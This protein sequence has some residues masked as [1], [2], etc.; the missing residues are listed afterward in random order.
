MSICSQGA[1]TPHHRLGGG[2][3]LAAGAKAPNA[4]RAFADP[5]I[6]TWR[7][8]RFVRCGVLAVVLGT[9]SL[10]P[11]GACHGEEVAAAAPPPTPASAAWDYWLRELR[12]GSDALEWSDRRVAHDWRLQEH[13]GGERWRLLDP[14]DE[15]V[16]AAGRTDCETTF[17]RLQAAGTIPTVSGPTV[18]VLHGLGQGRQSMQ[19]LVKHLRGTLDATVLSIGYASPRAGLEVHADALNEVISQLPEATT[20]SFVGHSLGNLVVRRW[21]ASAPAPTLSRVQ[22]MVMLGPPNQGSELARLASR[23]W[24]L[25][26]LSDGPT[27]QLG[28]E[29]NLVSSQLAVP[30]C[31]FG[32]VAGGLGD[33]RGMSMLLAGDDDAIVRVDETRLDGASGFLLLPVHHA[34][35]MRSRAVQRAAVCF[36]RDGFFPESPPP[37]IRV[38][39]ADRS[40]PGSPR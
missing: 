2:T 39:S 13:S 40:E 17:E 5:L 9:C 1:L 24:F 32:I 35:M 29:W 31:D 18:L 11:G 22:R 8:A 27:R 21:M 30:P 10:L 34:D 4:P 20:L 7:M 37:A 6:S 14:S 12:E 28:A 23:I 36:L 38:R 15:V 33:D 3:R 25:A 19:P 16:V 26:M